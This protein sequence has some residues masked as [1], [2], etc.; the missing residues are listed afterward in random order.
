M[1]GTMN[2]RTKIGVL[3]G[4]VL[5]LAAPAAFAQHGYGW[6]AGSGKTYDVDLELPPGPPIFRMVSEDSLNGR[7]EHDYFFLVKAK[8]NGVFD[9]SGGLQ[10]QE[11]F[12]VGKIDVWGGDDSKRYWTD[13][14][15]SQV[16][17]RGQRETAHGPLVGYMEGDFWGGSKHYR[18]RHL[19]VDY[20]FIHFGQDWTFFGDKEIWPNVMDWDGPPSGIWRREPELKFYFSRP[21]GWQFDIGTGQPGA[22]IRY[23]A[24]VDE[25]VSA[26][27]QPFPDIIGAVKKAAGFG[28]IRVTGIYRNLEYTQG[29]ETKSEP[30]FGGTVSGFVKTNSVSTNPIQFQFYAGQ[31]IATYV[32]SFSG[33][34][35]DAAADGQ[36][37]V[38]AIPTFGGWA[39]YE[40]FF[41]P[42][43]HVNL[44]GGF[45]IFDSDEFSNFTISGP[46]YEATD[47]SV[48]LQHYYGLF[49]V[50]WTP[51]P[52][53][54]F[55]IE[56][57]YGNQRDKYEGAIDTGDEVVASLEKS[58]DAHRISFG[59]FFDF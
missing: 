17:F 1:G 37:N 51:E 24:D 23:D 14:H 22:E 41:N 43:W 10:D 8:L 32:V 54:T 39:A 46:E 28:H 27:Y 50:M 9:I 56:Y 15:Q 7:P 26:A 34:D 29:T 31:G 2:R 25:T 4:L 19:W 58:R 18:L 45:S 35:Y 16:R 40:H 20:R 11:T 47:T 12:N 5:L 30:G 6:E 13:M 53:L 48:N 38:K 57:N 21:D 59:L 36:G 55:G 49:N 52:A 3:F 44:V 42:K 33:L